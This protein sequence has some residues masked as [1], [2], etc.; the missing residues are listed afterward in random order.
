[1]PGFT[2]SGGMIGLVRRSDSIV[3]EANP[4]AIRNSRL[5]LS[6]KVLKLARISRSTL[7]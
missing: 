1:V 2:Q 7:R 6:A 4:V 5:M 3:F